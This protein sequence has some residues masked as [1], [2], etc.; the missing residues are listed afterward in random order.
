MN[1]YSKWHIDGTLIYQ[2]EH[3]GWRKGEEL[4]QNRMT[5]SVQTFTGSSKDEAETLAQRIADFLN[6]PV[7]DAKPDAATADV[8]EALSDALKY[9]EFERHP[10]RP[11]HD[12]ARAAIAKATL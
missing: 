10:F 9:A 11:W 8:L 7:K 12:K 1:D 3:A 4:K 2:L 5:V 6:T